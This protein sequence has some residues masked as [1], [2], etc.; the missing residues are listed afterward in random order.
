MPLKRCGSVSDALQRVV[1]PAAAPPRTPAA[2]IA[3]H[4]GAAG[5]HRRHC[6][7]R[8]GRRAAMPACA[9]R[10]RSTAASR[11][12][13]RARRDPPSPGIAAP[14]SR[15]RSRP[16]I[17]RCTTTN[18]S[19]LEFEDEPLAEARERADRPALRARVERRVDGADEE[20]AREADAL[21]RLA[22]DPRPQRR[23]IELDV[24]QF[25]HAGAT[26]EYRRAPRPRRLDRPGESTPPG[27]V[28]A[29]TRRGH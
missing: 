12:E 13:S 18:R 14:R 3:K 19:S 24:G 7:A 21:D 17:I 20:R 2:S 29:G 28:A 27:P 11:R 6:R 23:Q 22:A 9:T 5:I 10:P 26:G 15:Q 1:G 16:A 8:R 4:V 25:R